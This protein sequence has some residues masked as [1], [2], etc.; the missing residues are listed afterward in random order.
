[1]NKPLFTWSN[2]KGYEC[3]SKGDKRFSAFYARV[4]EHSIEHHYQVNVK[5]YATMKDGK[6]KP[7]INKMS[8]EQTWQAYFNLWWQWADE[9]PDEIDD[10]ARL[11]S[12]NE[13]TL[14]D[15]FAKTPINQ[16]HALACILNEK[17]EAK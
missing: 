4:G 10:L 12:L 5:G 11:G 16:A 2:K 14:R 13:F 15:L 7:P 8:P 6:G 1:M 3:S 17:F 9:H